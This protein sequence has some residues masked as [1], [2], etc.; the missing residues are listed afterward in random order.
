MAM[1]ADEQD[2]RRPNAL[3]DGFEPDTRGTRPVAVL[4]FA[5][6]Y[7][8]VEGATTTA[9]DVVA[10]VSGLHIDQIPALTRH[11]AQSGRQRAGS[12]DVETVRR[13]GP[14]PTRHGSQARW[15]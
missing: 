4:M 13:G 5:G 9:S 6:L 11:S 3:A 15:H 14:V 12:V 1:V 8:I 7:I 2:N 10:A